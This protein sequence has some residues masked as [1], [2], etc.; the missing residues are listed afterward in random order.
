MVRSIRG[1]N[2][3]SFSLGAGY[4]EIVDTPMNWPTRSVLIRLTLVFLVTALAWGILA[5]ESVAPVYADHEPAVSHDPLLSQHFETASHDAV[6]SE[7]D[8]AG[9][10]YHCPLVLNRLSS[11]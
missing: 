10:S 11:S 9:P 4:K 7:H 6:L 8:Q 3:P 5:R 2:T 1:G